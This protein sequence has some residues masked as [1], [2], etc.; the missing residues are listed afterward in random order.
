M[1]IK[2]LN[3]ILIIDILTVLLILAILLIPSSVVRII[4]GLPFLLFFPGYALI[5]ALFPPRSHDPAAAAETAPDDPKNAPPDEKKKGMDNIERTAL[6]F[7][8]S[9]A[10]TALLGLGLNYTPWG[11][12]LLPVLITIS[13]FIIIMSAI[14]L[15]RQQRSAEGMR[16]GMDVHL[17]MPGWEGSALN[18]T[19]TVILAVA[20]LGS[21][22]TLAYTIAVPK[23][24]ERF[25]EFYIL[26]QNGKAEAY[27]SGFIMKDNQTVSV[28]YGDAGTTTRGGPGQVTLGIINREQQTATY[29]IAITI[30][31]QPAVIWLDGTPL[32]RVEQ[33]DLANDGKWEHQ[34]GFIPQHAGDNQKVEFLLFKNGAT[35]PENTL[36]IWV[37]VG[38]E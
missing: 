18:K 24:G 29:S 4:L 26:G 11:I 36:H 15:L 6:S 31:G 12:R 14:A 9:I 16:L 37:K 33:I 38:E 35:Q 28:Q 19:L 34:I 17:K 8:M 32:T 10:V 2:L 23:V 13:A 25:T 1:K 21:I 22:G 7:G 5:A 30:D 20:I 3:W 27:P